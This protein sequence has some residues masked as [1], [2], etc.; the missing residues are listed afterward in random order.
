[1]TKNPYPDR[2]IKSPEMSPISWTNTCPVCGEIKSTRE[3]RAKADKCSR[4]SQR[5]AMER[6]R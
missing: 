3:H 5:R 6:R 1:M 4:E 2:H